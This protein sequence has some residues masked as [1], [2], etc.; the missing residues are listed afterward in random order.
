MRKYFEDLSFIGGVLFVSSLCL[1]LLFRF[2]GLK[3]TSAWGD[4]VASWYYH[5]YFSHI[6]LYESHTP[7]YYFIC[8]VWTWVFPNTILSLRYLSIFL[9]LALVLFA[10]CFITKK[11]DARS[12]LLLFI[13]WWL[14]PTAIIFSRQARHYSLYFDLTILICL[15]WTFK[16]DFKKWIFWALLAIYSAIHPI[17]VLPVIFLS[18][19]DFVKERKIKDFVFW[20][21]SCLPVSLYYLLRLIFIGR[22]KVHSNI[23]WINSSSSEFAES[24]FNLFFGDSF[25]FSKFY[26]IDLRAS[27]LLLVVLLFIA[28]FRN[29][30]SFITSKT[31]LQ[32]IMF[33]VLTIGLVETLGAFSFNLRINRYFIYLPAFF[34]FALFHTQ[35][36]RSPRQLIYLSFVIFTTLGLYSV[37]SF[38]PWL[39]YTWDDQNIETF[40]LEISKLP[41]KDVVICGNPFQLR[42]Y[43][44]LSYYRCSERAFELFN[45]N[46]EFYFFDI[47]GNDKLTA[48]YLL[49]NGKVNFQRTYDHALLLSI[50]A[51]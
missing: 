35:Q 13:L 48:I 46:K 28:G 23:A 38:R 4:E 36:S 16:K 5:Q 3:E 44:N 51:K 10:S 20:L 8:K 40:N 29:F 15:L 21:S 45:K 25:P 12:G 43:F 37:L 41:S 47:N 50:E 6:F 18:S 33:T 31:F 22:E 19:W 1:G 26:P 24:L 17:A 2:I 49:E 7:V 27:L 32:W 42:Y 9:S 30:K 14:W 34:I 11:R 39:Y